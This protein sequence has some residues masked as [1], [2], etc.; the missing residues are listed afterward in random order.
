M[1]GSKPSGGAPREQPPRPRSAAPW[2]KQES[3]YAAPAALTESE[4]AFVARMEA[5]SVRRINKAFEEP[6]DQVDRDPPFR[7][8]LQPSLRKTPEVD[9]ARAEVHLEVCRGSMSVHEFRL[10]KYIQRTSDFES[11]LFS[12]LTGIAFT[13]NDADF[14]KRV[15]SDNPIPKNR[16]VPEPRVGSFEVHLRYWI[17]QRERVYEKHIRLF[18][19]IKAKKWPNIEKIVTCVRNFLPIK[20]DLDPEYEPEELS[21][22]PSDPQEPGTS[23]GPFPRLA[24]DMVHADHHERMGVDATSSP[25]ECEAGPQVMQARGAIPEPGMGSRPDEDA[26]AAAMALAFSDSG[27]QNTTDGEG[28]PA[29]KVTTLIEEDNVL[30][31]NSTSGTLVADAQAVQPSMQEAA[32]RSAVDC[33]AEQQS[34]QTQDLVAKSSKDA[35]GS[36]AADDVIA[37]AMALAF[38]GPA[39][40]IQADAAQPAANATSTGPSPSVEE[41]PSRAPTTAYGDESISHHAEPCESV[42]D[43]ASSF[44]IHSA[45]A[46]DAES[47]VEAEGSEHL[48]APQEESGP[49][50]PS[51]MDAVGKPV[52]IKNLEEIEPQEDDGSDYSSAD[53]FV[54]SLP[55]ELDMDEYG[56]TPGK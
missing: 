1:E 51:I 34:A 35:P 26:I 39:A 47:E 45:V 50:P 55:D 48:N 53:S 44:Q 28:R 42:G 15:R 11:E 22:S 20:F 2:L 38:P 7:Y 24:T 30:L 9:V 40:P 16:W 56:D 8:H 52:V 41:Q 43:S 27:T 14:L 21:A 36:G 4:V 29:G 25:P 33:D 54:E 5:D 17:R 49:R 13:K 46:S 19:K 10:P 32:P 3:A 18:S 6:E 37:A 31:R 23:K 12:K